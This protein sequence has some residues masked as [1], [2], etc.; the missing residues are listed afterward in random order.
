MRTALYKHSKIQT[1]AH[2]T[3]MALKEHDRKNLELKF[4]NVVDFHCA[5]NFF[6]RTFLSQNICFLIRTATHCFPIMW[7]KNTFFHKNNTLTTEIQQFALR[8]GANN[9]I[10]KLK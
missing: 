2:K 9:L 5:R 6:F 1:A 8:N 7:S 4:R 3:V 10:L